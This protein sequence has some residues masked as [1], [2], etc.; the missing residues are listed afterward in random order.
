MLKMTMFDG[1]MKVKTMLE[2]S[3]NVYVLLRTP[4]VLHDP[5]VSARLGTV[6][7]GKHTCDR[8]FGCVKLLVHCFQSG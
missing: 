1:M 7:D 2:Q 5:V 4:G 3:I 6:A 8:Q